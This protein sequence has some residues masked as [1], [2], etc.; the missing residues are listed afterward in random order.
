MN[1]EEDPKALV[2]SK[3]KRFVNKLFKR[4]LKVV[5]LM[6]VLVFT[7]SCGRKG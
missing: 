5:A 3:T 7:P 1:G 4:M 2:L 6:D